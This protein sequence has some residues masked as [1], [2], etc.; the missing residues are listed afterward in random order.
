MVQGY[1]RLKLMVLQIYKYGRQLQKFSSVIL[2]LFYLRVYLSPYC[3][4]WSPLSTWLFSTSL[5][6]YSLK[7]RTRQ[8]GIQT[9]CHDAYNLHDAVNNCPGNPFPRYETKC[10]VEVESCAWL[11][12]CPGLHGTIFRGDQSNN[13]A[14]LHS[15]SVA[16]S[17]DVTCSIDHRQW[18]FVCC[19][20]YCN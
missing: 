5:L 6:C 7:G 19:G 20:Y 10:R 17:L 18:A 16:K 14:R 2:A 1:V 9:L 4:I 12:D 15:N 11:V 8:S 3:Y 13:R